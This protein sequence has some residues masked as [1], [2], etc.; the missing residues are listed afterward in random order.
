[1]REPRF[2]DIATFM[3]APL[4]AALD[5][6]DIGLIGIPTDLGSRIVRAPG[7]AHAKS[8]TLRA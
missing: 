1:M 7:T 3:R 2:T 6:V 4:A 5:N 8:A